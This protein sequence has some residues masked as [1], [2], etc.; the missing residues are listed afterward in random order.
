LTPRTLIIFRTKSM[1]APCCLPRFLVKV[2]G[3]AS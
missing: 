3:I 2:V 1:M